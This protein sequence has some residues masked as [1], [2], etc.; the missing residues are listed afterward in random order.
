MP[1]IFDFDCTLTKDHTFNDHAIERALPAQNQYTLGQT[2]GKKNIKNGVDV[3]LNHDE[4]DL[5]A[6]ATYHNNPEFVAGNISAIL[7]KEL[8]LVDTIR[9]T[10][11]NAGSS[12]KTEIAINIYK[13]VGI[14]KPFLISYL[15]HKGNAFQSAMR[16]LEN[17]NAQISAIR[18]FWLAKGFIKGTD[19]IDFYEDSSTNFNAAK[20]LDYING[21]L[22]T[23]SNEHTVKESYKAAIKPLQASSS[24]S[25]SPASPPS[26]QTE[27]TNSLSMSN[28]SMMV[29]G[30]FIAAAGIAAT[31]I[32]FTVLNA[33]TLGIPGLL[34]AGAGIAAVLA[35]CGL[36]ASNMN[37]QTTP[38]TLDFS[39]NTVKA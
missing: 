24:L 34:L 23:A 36:F 15:P 1:A 2:E 26:H 35:G 13:V 19:N 14:D 4:Q 10:I 17:K 38:N 28:I 21:Y 20:S 5:S 37:K 18:E 30:G 9:K 3:V 8:T 12:E 25:N 39:M 11:V 32:A 6:V 33:A 31:A 22:V 29:L 16:I 7:K 27:K